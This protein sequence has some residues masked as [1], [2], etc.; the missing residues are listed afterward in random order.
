MKI[1]MFIGLLS[2]FVLST[3]LQAASPVPPATKPAAPI[4]SAKTTGSINLNSADVKT[5]TNSVK[6]IGAKRAEAIVKYRD[7]Q[8]GFKSIEELANVPGLGK[9]F[10]EHNRQELE[11][12]FTLG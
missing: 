11:R 1:K 5:L 8:H 7:A 10:V 3:A 4:N 9:R 2:F 6:G 12:V